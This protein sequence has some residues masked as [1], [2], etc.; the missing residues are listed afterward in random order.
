MST[1]TQN[2][3]LTAIHKADPKK[4][5]V[6]FFITVEAKEALARWCKSRDVTESGAIEEMIRLIVLES[7]EQGSEKRG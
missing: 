2:Q 3:I 6:S 5:R 7:P 4:K 1:P